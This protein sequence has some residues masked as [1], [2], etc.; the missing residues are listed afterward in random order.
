MK[1]SLKIVYLTPKNNQTLK[2][3]TLF[4]L[5]FLPVLAFSQISLKILDD[6][7]KPV[8]QANVTYNNQIYKTDNNGFIKV[9]LYKTEMH[10][11]FL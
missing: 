4:I 2:N 3:Y 9:F 6:D 11:I 5:F 7:G 10:Y 8:S 1:K